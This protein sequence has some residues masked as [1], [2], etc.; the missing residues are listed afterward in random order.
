[1]PQSDGI[2]AANNGDLVACTGLADHRHEKRDVRQLVSILILPAAA[3]GLAVLPALAQ[4]DAGPGRPPGMASRLAAER[5][6]AFQPGL[7]SAG[8]NNSFTLQP[9]GEGKYLLRFAQ[10]AETFVL[11]MEHG[12]M[13]AKVMKYDTGA[14]ALRVSVWGGVTLYTRDAPQGL[15]ATYQ[16]TAAPLA[17]PAISAGELETAFGDETGHLGYVQN[18]T[19]KFFAEPGVL[20]SDAEVRGRAFA[21]MTDAAAGIERF[22]AASAG[23][24]Q[25]LAR[26]IS[27]VKL[28]EG[29]R[30]TITITGQTLL[31]SFVPAEGREGHASSLAIQQ[32]LMRLLALSPHD[33][34]TK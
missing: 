32:E 13:G 7:Y 8:D 31:V 18:I 6:G 15:P 2:L 3:L 14:T 9:Y 16:G 25:L 26:R 21:A 4:L 11:T 30:P 1:M 19:L 27:S 20:A 24:R 17:A 34:A 5:V 22:V 12:S 29:A 33:V 23:A 28:A 10:G